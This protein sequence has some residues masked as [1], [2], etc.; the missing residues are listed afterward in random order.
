MI[1]RL[2]A[3]KGFR[4][5]YE[6]VDE[7]MTLPALLVIL[8]TGDSDI[9]KMVR[10]M[11]AR[12]PDQIKIRIEFNEPLAH[13]IEA[14]ADIFLMPSSYEP[15]GLN[16]LYSLRYG[17]IPIVHA[18]GGLDDS[19]IDVRLEPL[20][21]TGFKFYTYEAA[22]FFDVIKAALELFQD[23]TK[24]TELQ[25]RAMGQEFSWKRSAEQYLKVYERA[26]TGC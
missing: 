13:R 9:G 10:G 11:A 17:T 8:G 19:V 23:K 1:A 20:M 2:A 15:C 21:G 24:W 6:I 18:T 7:L 3:Q 12:Y 22:A 14:G 4:L 26:L 5:L 25:R 16:Q